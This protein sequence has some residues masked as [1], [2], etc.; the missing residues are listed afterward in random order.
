MAVNIWFRDLFL[1]VSL[2][3]FSLFAIPMSSVAAGADWSME[4]VHACVIPR[5]M[6]LNAPLRAHLARCLGWVSAEAQSPCCGG[7]QPLL[8]SPLPHEKTLRIEAD[9]VSFYPSGRSSMQ[10]HVQVQQ[11]LQIVSAQT[12]YIYRDAKTKQITQIQ[13]IGDVRLADP[14]KLVI[15]NKADMNPQDHSGRIE[16]ALYRFNTQHASAVL[17]A[18]GRAGLLQKFASENYLLRKATYS[19][20]APQD[21]AWQIEAGEISIDQVKKKGV[22]KDA[23]LRV[24]DWPLL[25]T[26]YLSFPTAKERKSGFLMPLYGYSNVGG[27]DLGLP[28]YWNIAPNYDAT[29]VPHVYSRRGVMMG[30]DVRFLTSQST[31]VASAHVLP[32]DRA[33][34]KYIKD[35]RVQYPSLRQESDNR[36]SLLLHDSTQWNQNLHMGINYQQ[37]S[38]NYYLQDFSTNLAVATQNQLPR[39]GDLTWHSEHWLLSGMVQSY[40]TLHPV[41]QSMI[42][43]IYQRLPQ[44]LARGRYDELPFNANFSVLG[45]FDNFYWPA[46]VLMQPQGPRYH[47]NPVLSLSEVASWGYVR[48]SVQLVENYY[49]VRYDG[50]YSPTTFNRTI[51]RYSVDSGLFFERSSRALGHSMTQTLEPRLFYLN[52]PYQNQAPIP[53]YDTA[54]MIF[55][56]DQLFRLNRFSGFDR[57]SDANQLAYAVTSRWL[58]D[59][60]GRERASL[61][62]GQIKYF[63]NRRVQLCYDYSGICTDSPYMLGYLSPLA[64]ASPI[65]SRA[66]YQLTDAWG[67]SADYA[68]DGHTNA[69]NNGYLNFHYQPQA[70]R[71]LNLGYTYLVNGDITQ[72]A[73]GESQ[74][75]ALHQATV[76][77]AVPLSDKWSSLGVYSHNISKNYGMM[78]FLGFQYDSCCW[79]VRLLGGR[80]FKS[81]SPTTLNPQYNNNVYLQILLKGLGSA[82][83]GDPTSTIRT[84]IPG[85]RDIFQH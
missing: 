11:G 58:S 40:Q 56:T 82:A 16:D 18:W 53:V 36:W 1:R 80:T 27:F 55:N 65:A 20:C 77:Y 37:V 7:Y 13:L 5:S 54:Y 64:K 46:S 74:L 49:D 17:P 83:S 25:Y 51:P 52:V 19:T 9:E 42:S 76:S 8:I 66:T 73:G 61:S 60:T 50:A 79:A 85:Y 28:Y 84:Y 29:L 26:P 14:D 47:L 67:V 72:I 78:T 32:G 30:G 33:F 57:I 12:A 39:Q 41:N 21:N 75:G 59:T 68:W 2:V 22:A 15:A 34:A 69:T 62:V 43:D 63:S 24:G 23:V 70:D 10:G 44:L 45:Q 71:L 35:N 3:V 38:D 48:P 4:P 31:G 81:L 6:P